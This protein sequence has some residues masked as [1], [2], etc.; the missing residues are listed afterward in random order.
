MTG[1]I[2]LDKQE[3]SLT[4]KSAKAK[5]DLP[6]MNVKPLKIPEPPAGFISVPAK[7][8]KKAMSFAAA[9]ADTK[10]S[11]NY[12]GVVQV[13]SLDLGIE[14][15][16]P[17][18]YRII[19]A[20]EMSL[21]AVT[22]P[23]PVSEF[24]FSLNLPAANLVQI[25]DGTIEFADAEKF[26]WFRSEGLT[27]LASKRDESRPE[28][29]YPEN[30][31]NLFAVK[32]KLRFQFNPE[33]W[34]NALKTIEPLIEDVDEGGVALHLENSVLVLSNRSNTAT[35][36]AGYEQVDPDPI[37]EPVK[38]SGLT[39]NA[40]HWSAFLSKASNPAYINLTEKR[41]AVKLESGNIMTLVM[42]L[43][44]KKEPK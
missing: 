34:L 25:M 4:L 2:E 21:T 41:G 33:E 43:A 27:V 28:Y 44:N 6:I 7:P 9:S 38:V 23:Q 8:F 3:K 22:E 12:G 13:R 19:G 15:T 32:P 35:D 42:P 30:Y 26:I 1:Q 20:E 18:G 14:D 16:S 11:A 37:F 31:A 36:E 39:L 29:R 17:Q 5:I 10:K 40:K 24:K